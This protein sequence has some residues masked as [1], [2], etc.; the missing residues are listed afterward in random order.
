M[1]SFYGDKAAGK[2]IGDLMAMRASRPW[3]D[4]LEA[5][6][7]QSPMSSSAII[8]YFAPLKAWL[9]EQ[10]KGQAVGWAAE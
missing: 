2:R 4:A 6:R 8:E 10:N 3:P 7:G 1:I 5:M 9:D